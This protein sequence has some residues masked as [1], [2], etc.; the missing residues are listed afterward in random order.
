MFEGKKGLSG[1]VETW[2]KNVQQT[3]RKG[4]TEDALRFE[5]GERGPVG[6]VET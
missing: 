5:I 2:S 6:R 1:Q 4:E 3:V